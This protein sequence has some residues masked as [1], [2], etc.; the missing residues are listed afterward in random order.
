MLKMA[1]DKSS[2]MNFQSRWMKYYNKFKRIKEL[3]TPVNILPEKTFARQQVHG[4]AHP[5][6]RAYV[7]IYIQL[8]S[9]LDEVTI[10]LWKEQSKV[11]RLN[12][13]HEVL[14]HGVNCPQQYYL[15]VETEN[16]AYA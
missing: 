16:H 6:K 9:A 13:L 5:S 2:Y 11:E 1:W 4:F 7:C 15:R 3:R 12:L 8:I 10:R 14:F